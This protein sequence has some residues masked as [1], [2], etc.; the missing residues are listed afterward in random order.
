MNSPFAAPDGLPNEPKSGST[1]EPKLP[2]IDSSD[3]P[4][5][6]S[7]EFEVVQR[8]TGWV[9]LVLVGLGC[10]VVNL[11]LPSFL[12]ELDENLLGTLLFGC[13]MAQVNLIAIWG[14]MASGRFLLRMPWSFAL[15]TIM[16][17]SL[18]MGCYIV[19]FESTM[20]LKMEDALFLGL[21]LLFSMPIAMAPLSI[22]RAIFK[23]K[24]SRPFNAEVREQMSVGLLLAGI[25]LVGVLMALGRA[26]LPDSPVRLA[27]V[28]PQIFLVLGVVI[29]FN[30]V[31]TTPAIWLSF[32][33][34][35]MMPICLFGV[36]AYALMLTL[37][38]VFIFTLV[39]GAGPTYWEGLKVFGGLN[40]G[41][42]L[43]VMTVL[44]CLRLLGFQLQRVGYGPTSSPFREE[45]MSTGLSTPT[46][47]ISETAITRDVD[48]LFRGM[49]E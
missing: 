33:P 20:S 18:V 19:K 26:I 47:P 25:T 34:W 2:H 43:T 8:A 27:N 17:Y 12:S 21:V 39:A 41:Q 9:F 35:R 40:I 11:A 44:V 42:V 23:W 49:D 5:N 3:S 45:K 36:I 31:Q 38:E 37:I 29:V 28:P 46:S 4:P 6:N 14:V 24:L 15:L 48:N 30:L 13:C 1:S 16:W 32:F 10:I 7:H 22:L